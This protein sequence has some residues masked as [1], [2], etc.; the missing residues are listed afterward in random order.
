MLKNL[1]EMIYKSA[2][3]YGVKNAYKGYTYSEV[4]NIVDSLGS[5]LIDMGLKDKRIAVIG[6]NRF[7]W[8]MAYLAITC[9]TGVVVP[10]DKA[11]PLNELCSVIK[12]SEIEAIFFSKK[13]VEELS[14]IKYLDNNF[15]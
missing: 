9:G 1:K 8:E 5:K 7:E 14:K 4:K 6:E 11:L 13:Y 10:L 2:E 12:R 3:I 15:A